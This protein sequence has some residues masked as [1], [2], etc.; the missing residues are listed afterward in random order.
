MTDWWDLTSFI[1]FRGYFYADLSKLA[2]SCWFNG[3]YLVLLQVYPES[4][5]RRAKR[6]RSHAWTYGAV[7]SH[8]SW[9]F[10][11]LLL[12]ALSAKHGLRCEWL[13]APEHLHQ[14][15]SYKG[16]HGQALRESKM[17]INII[18]LAFCSYSWV[19]FIW[20]IYIY[21]YMDMRGLMYTWYKLK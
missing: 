19:L 15:Q 7:G 8:P 9:Q 21:R 4:T 17:R 13:L 18:E 16:Y 1:F 12:L 10:S 2:D 5:L 11:H 6:L 20:Y 3:V 14:G